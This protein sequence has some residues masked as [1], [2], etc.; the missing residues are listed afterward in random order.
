MLFGC[1]PLFNKLLD[2]GRS[3][4]QWRPLGFP[5]LHRWD[6]GIATCGVRSHPIFGNPQE[7]GDFCYGEEGLH[8]HVVDRGDQNQRAGS[9]RLFLQ[10]IDSDLEDSS[11]FGHVQRSI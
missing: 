1:R 8:R 3:E 11:V 7:I 4:S 9:R 10:A 2:I 5:H 6:S